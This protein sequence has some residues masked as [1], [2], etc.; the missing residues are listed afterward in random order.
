MFR[1]IMVHVDGLEGTAART[2]LSVTLAGKF[3]AIFP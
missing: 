2:R 3:D 1:T